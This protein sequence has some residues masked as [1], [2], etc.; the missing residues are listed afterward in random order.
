[1]QLSIKT[2]FPE[3]SKAL[4]ALQK[5]IADKALASALNKTLAQ[6]K[7]AMSKSITSEF[8]ISASKVKDS[9]RVNRV[10]KV[11]GAYVLQGSLESPSKRGRSLN[12]INFDA[13]KTAAGISVKI[14]K[15]GG[16][17]VLRGAFIGNQGRTVFVRVG[18]KRLPIKA[19]QTVE[20]AQMFNTK[21]INKVV[22]DFLQAKLPEVFENEA[23][24]FNEKFNNKRST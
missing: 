10:R 6:G 16:R 21:R 20:V 1:M 7:T 23:K 19:L 5:D 22:V 14:K 2:N 8:N 13:R 18:A 15:T 11:A 9:L 3:I 17:K 12:L 4:N 24:F